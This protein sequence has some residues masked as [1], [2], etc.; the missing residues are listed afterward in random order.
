MIKKLA[1]FSLLS[2]FAVSSFAGQLSDY[3]QYQNLLNNDNVVLYSYWGCLDDGYTQQD[4]QVDPVYYI[5]IPQGDHLDASVT[6]TLT[7][8]PGGP[9][10]L[11]TD[12]IFIKVEIWD[13]GQGNLSVGTVTIERQTVY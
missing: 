6:I 1:I 12:Y 5:A 13:D 10:S 11:V 2:V 4:S 8:K 7:R 9:N 3:P